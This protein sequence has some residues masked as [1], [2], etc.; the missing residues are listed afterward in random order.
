VT[1]RNAGTDLEHLAAVAAGK[2]EAARFL[3]PL[4]QMPGGAANHSRDR[5][6]AAYHDWL[7]VSFHL[8]ACRSQGKASTTSVD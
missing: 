8:Q 4:L 3:T 6:P 7:T 5:A 1:P 2:Q